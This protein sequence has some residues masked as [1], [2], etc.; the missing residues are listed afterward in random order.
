MNAPAGNPLVHDPHYFLTRS[1]EPIRPFLDDPKVVEIAINKPGH[2]YVE[3][4][5]A[6]H[7]EHHLIDVLTEQ[8]IENIGERVAASTKQFLNQANPILSAALPTGERIQVVLPPQL[9]TVDR[10]RSES[11]SSRTSRLKITGTMDRSI[12][13]RSP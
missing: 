1:L 8:E 7:M 2:V 3:R 10:L 4:F 12:R 5:G 9:L 13:C 11:R 6:D